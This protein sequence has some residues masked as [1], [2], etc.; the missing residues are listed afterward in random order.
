VGIVGVVCII[1]YIQIIGVNLFV[2]RSKKYVFGF[3]GV[4]CHFV[5]FKPHCNLIDFTVDFA[6]E[7]IKVI[8]RV[9]A[10]GIIC[11]HKRK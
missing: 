8:I 7:V 9:Q 4:Y 3:T 6:N 1:I 11:K 2:F 5:G 10:T